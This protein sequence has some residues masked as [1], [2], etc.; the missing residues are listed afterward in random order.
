MLARNKLIL[1]TI[2]G[3]CVGTIFVTI[4]MLLQ[5][6]PDRISRSEIAGKQIRTAHNFP[7]LKFE[8]IHCIADEVYIHL[9]NFSFQE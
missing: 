7:E 9:L 2:T 4:G 8:T 3:L 6:N 1:G 5:Y